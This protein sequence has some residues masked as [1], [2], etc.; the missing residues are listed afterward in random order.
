MSRRAEVIRKTKETDITIRVEIDGKGKSD[1]KTGVGFLDHMLDSLTTHSL[2]DVTVRAKGDLTHHIVEDVAISLGKAVGKALGDR[3]GIRRF[4]D[5]I[6]PMDDGLALA[7]VDLVKRPYSAVDLKLERVMLEDAPREDL[8]H[9]FGSMAQALEATVHIKVLDGS[10]D[11]H[12]FE[13]AVKA[14]ALALRE[15]ASEDPR[16]AEI[17]TPPSSKGSM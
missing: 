15:A 1:A 4:G 14:F 8:E 2:M 10:N 3:V 9:F 17:K 11:H 12:K 13:A 16:R 5:A 7:A 6:V